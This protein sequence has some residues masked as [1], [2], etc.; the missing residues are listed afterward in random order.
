MST[1][2]NNLGPG[3]KHV[4]ERLIALEEKQREFL[5]RR[6]NACTDRERTTLENLAQTILKLVEPRLDGYLQ[7]YLWLCQEQV[8]EEIHFRRNGRYRL[9][10]F[11]E[12]LDQVYSNKEYMS[13]YM[14]GLLMTQLF[15]SNHTRIFSFYQSDFLASQPPGSTHLEIGPGHGLLLHAA[16]TSGKFTSCESW[17][18]SET[19]IAQTRHCLDHLGGGE[20]VTL[21]L[22]DMF[23]AE[24]G[25]FDSIVFAE[26]LEHM[27]HPEQAVEVLKKNLSADGRLFIHMPINSP[28]PDHLFNCET[29]EVFVQFLE[30]QGLK[31]EAHRF[32]P[33]TG[34]TLEQATELQYTIS[35]GLILRKA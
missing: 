28:A 31:V 32:E 2:F 29:P 20:A 30:D 3:T 13:R 24:N 18:I 21:K 26:V 11:Q 8:T 34:L 1:P 14:N 7:D 17:D 5:E 35:C 23:A 9:N 25:E 22:Q 27:E 15:W 12:A 10:T 4:F 19:S 16:A 33:A 6:M